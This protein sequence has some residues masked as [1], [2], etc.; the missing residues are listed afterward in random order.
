MKTSPA[1]IKIK[2]TIGAILFALVVTTPLAFQNCGQPL[3]SVSL[4]SDDPGT[5][6]TQSEKLRRQHCA[7]CHDG[8]VSSPRQV[9][10][11]DD[12]ALIRA[13]W[14]RPGDPT[15]SILY[16]SLLTN[17][18]PGPSRL[19]EADIDVFARWIQNLTDTAA[20]LMLSEASPYSFGVI[21][22]GAALEKTFTVI[23]TGHRAATEVSLLGLGSPFQLVSSQTCGATI[24]PGTPC[25]VIVRFQ[26]ETAGLFNDTLEVSY[27][28][29][30]NSQ[31]VSLKLD[32]KGEGSTTPSAN[33]RFAQGSSGVFGVVSVG[34]AKTLTFTVQNI[35]SGG[36]SGLG[37][38]G[39]SAPF[40]FEGGNF[41]G[42]GGTCSTTLAASASCTVVLRF[43]P[44]AP[45]PQSKDVKL[46][47]NSGTGL[48]NVALSLSGTGGSTAA[49]LYYSEIRQILNNSACNSCHTGSFGD[50]G[51]NYA[52]LLAFKYPAT[53]ASSAIAPGSPN[54]RFL[55][56]IVSGTP[57]GHLMGGGGGYGILTA[58]DRQ[59]IIDWVLAGAPDDP[60]TPP[61]VLT[62]SDSPTYNFGDVQTG[63]LAEHVFTVSNTGAR[64]AT[65]L[66]GASFSN[67]AFSFKGG[68]YP[69][70][71]GTCGSIL[72]PAASCTV[73]VRFSPTITGLQSASLTINYNDGTSAKTVS[74]AVSGNGTGAPLPNLSFQ[75]G[76]QGAFSPATVGDYSSLSLTVLNSGAAVSDLK[77]GLVSPS[78]IRTGGSCAI[79][80][81]AG[82]SCT[83]TLRFTPSAAGDF[84]GSLTL[85]YGGT[86]T[87][88]VLSLTLTGKGLNVNVGQI[89]FSSVDAILKNKCGVCHSPTFGTGI[90]TVYDSLLKFK[91]ASQTTPAINLT[92]PASSRFITAITTGTSYIAGGNHIMGKDPYGSLTTNDVE[93]IVNWIKQG[94]PKASFPFYYKPLI[95]DR[96]YTTSVLK[97][98]F[99]ETNATVNSRLLNLVQRA[100]LRG[101]PCHIQDLEFTPAGTARNKPLPAGTDNC[102]GANAEETRL[103]ADVL[104]ASST[105]AE[106]MRIT[107]C[108]QLTS[109]MGK[110]GSSSPLVLEDVLARA[111]LTPSS[112]F[113]AAS[114]TKAYNQF[115]PGAT[116]NAAVTTALMNIGL[117]AQRKLL[118][119]PTVDRPREG[120]RFIYVALCSSPGWQAP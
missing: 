88:K 5:L 62:L 8:S 40:G 48:Q 32:L 49:G 1:Q 46:S 97:K 98:V 57:Q 107:V 61:A 94:A 116:P 100:D 11:M 89:Q 101:A 65:T 17:M 29:G 12:E 23:N 20:N 41:P 78:F 110:P 3:H 64:N 106:S 86:V 37:V 118:N 21:T 73:I 70:A 66:T 33:L 50:W 103:N 76:T 109:D 31:V 87:P 83:I 68:I 74:R 52:A 36:A 113:D 45:G 19:S 77:I 84:N 105:V 71:G 51:S 44:T 99:G 10:I 63:A 34:S 13:G 38:I 60:A 54:S 96:Y 53:Q 24:E 16:Q 95:G 112:P 18:P 117:E 58:T 93:I 79:V 75:T 39:L 111:N 7:S 55:T 15:N 14:V 69:G 2:W 35:G 6:Q 25:S 90:T 120:W 114:V 91:D 81:A 26:P 28:D 72:N 92:N 56:A 82:A 59:K 22:A 85:T 67:N 27:R 80:L 9:N 4:P 104:P 47:Y 30:V 43:A 119:V 108:M 115:Y 102:Y 42:T